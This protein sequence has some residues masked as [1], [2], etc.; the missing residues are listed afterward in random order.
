ME[1][2]EKG[3]TGLRRRVLGDLTRACRSGTTKT[4][5]KGVRGRRHSGRDEGKS[6]VK[7]SRKHLF[8]PVTWFETLP[9]CSEWSWE[10]SFSKMVSGP[11]THSSGQTR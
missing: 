3:E 9:F 8:L 6:F 10:R 5:S 1:G 4:Q 11:E 2:V 7:N